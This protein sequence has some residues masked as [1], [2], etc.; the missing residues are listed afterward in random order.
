LY[1]PPNAEQIVFMSTIAS[2][3]GRSHTLDEFFAARDAA[4]RGVRFELADGELLVTPSPGLKH[5]IVAARLF[6]RLHDYVRDNRL[7]EL[8]FAPL[9]VRFAER[10]VLQ[11]DL[12]LVAAGCPPEESMLAATHLSLAVEILSNGSARHDRVT[13]RTQYQKMGIPEYWIVDGAAGT[14][15]RWRPGDERPEICTAVLR[16]HPPGSLMA[17]DVTLAELFAAE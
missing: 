2:Y 17:L 8:L 11:P 13:K 4:P 12:L 7:G 10:S 3:P 16:W 15:E 1:F 6:A 14:V 5:Q 9:D